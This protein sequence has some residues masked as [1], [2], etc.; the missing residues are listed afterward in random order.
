MDTTAHHH[1]A[2]WSLQEDEGRGLHRFRAAIWPCLFCICTVNLDGM[3]T[4][5]TFSDGPGGAPAPPGPPP[6]SRFADTRT[7][8]GGRGRTRAGADGRRRR[9]RIHCG[10][11]SAPVCVR[12]RIREAAWRGVSGGGGSPPWSVGFYTTINFTTI[13]TGR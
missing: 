8:A 11:P 10:R 7:D 4:R 5:Q 3:T 2:L 6:S 9:A 12:P 1:V 13:T